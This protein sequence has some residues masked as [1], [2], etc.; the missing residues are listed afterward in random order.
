M[1]FRSWAMHAIL[2]SAAWLAPVAGAQ[3]GRLPDFTDLYEQQ[4]PAV[5]SIDVTQKARRSQ[6]PNL[7]ED[8]PF[9]EF[10]RRFGPIPRG[11]PRPREF[12]QQAMG[13][14]FIL[15]ADGYV[16]TKRAKSPS[17]CPTSASS[18]PR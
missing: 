17:S 9:S 7:S 3:V 11:Q 12:D 14:G 8:D 15:T 10:F 1:K 5:V 4:A 2:L 16:L 13:S 18:R 6:F